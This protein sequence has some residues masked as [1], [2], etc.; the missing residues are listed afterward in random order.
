MAR[1]DRY[2]L[3]Q[4]LLFF[5]FFALILVAVFWINRA[6]KL[7]DW[8]IG[9]GQS[10]LVFLEFSALVLP[11]LIRT[12][13]PL[14][15]FA[16]AVYVTNRL[17]V[18]SELTAM[19]ATGSG[20]W[21]LSRPALM[22]GLVSAVMMGI[23]TNILLPASLAQLEKREGEISRNLTARLLSEG[24]FLHPVP[25]VTFFIR[26]IDE[27]GLL[28]DVFLSDNRKADQI[29]TFTASRA[30][31]VREDEQASL[32]MVDGM[33]QRLDRAGRTLSTTQFA[34]FS[35]DITGLIKKDEAKRRDIRALQTFELARAWDRIVADGHAS[36]GD[37]AEELHLRIARALICVA[38]ALVGYSAMMLGGFSR[39]GAW[40][41]GML[42]FVLLIVTELMRGLVTDPVL[43]DAALW[44][45]LYLPT[46]FGLASAFVF[47]RLASHPWQP[48][49]G[50]KAR[51]A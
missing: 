4:Y 1:Y 8:L 20:P 45:L 33:A 36:D 2:V 46:L 18:E 51:S 7:F 39:F 21:R 27:E 3:S 34:D 9:D 26:D 14:A 17:R 13:L 28:N 25:G 19:Q 24:R 23:L 29:V 16:A 40:R 10:V 38:V 5:G 31:L 15:V 30:F 50:G 47:L 12:V 11:N 35:Y 48:R 6:V 49:Q 37:V 22:L 44:P 42:A 41:Q 43:K 32:V